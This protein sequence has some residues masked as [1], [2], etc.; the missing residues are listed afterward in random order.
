VFDAEK[1]DGFDQPRRALIRV[2]PT[3]ECWYH[4]RASLMVE[5]NRFV[6]MRVSVYLACDLVEVSPSYDTD[7]TTAFLTAHFIFELLGSLPG[8]RKR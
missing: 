3:Q 2:V 8:C 7:E 4:L 1:N 5:I 6:G